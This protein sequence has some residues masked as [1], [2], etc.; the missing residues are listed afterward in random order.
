MN[1]SEPDEPAA[2]NKYVLF[3]CD[4]DDPAAVALDLF[5]DVIRQGGVGNNDMHLVQVTEGVGQALVDLGGVQEENNQSCLFHN[6]AFQFTFA[7]ITAG[8]SALQG[9]TGGGEEG[10]IDVDIG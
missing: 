5:G 10:D 2:I 6:D 9:Q 8:E 3:F 4:I 7:V 1:I